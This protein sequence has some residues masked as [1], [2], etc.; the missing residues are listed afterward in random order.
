MTDLVI[1]LDNPKALDARTVLEQTILCWEN[2]NAKTYSLKGHEIV[3]RPKTVQEQIDKCGIGLGYYVPTKPEMAWKKFP[4]N[5]YV[6]PTNCTSVSDKSQAINAI[7]DCF[8][9]YN[10]VLGKSAFVLV[11][12]SSMAKIK[13]SWASQDGP[14]G[15]LGICNYSYYSTGELISSTI[16]FDS[17]DSW[18]TENVL[19]CGYS[20]T[21]YN[22]R[23][24]GKHEIGH[25]L[26]LSHVYN[27]ERSTMFHTMKKGEHRVLDKGTVNGI[28]YLY[29]IL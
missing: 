21:K 10:V 8:Q 26:G 5:F 24:C 2:L 9:E 25:A 14:N 29:K 18:M 6:D 23:E 15:R 16:K 13:I 28:K 1:D 19:Q 22:M 27:D 20:G 11:T 17:A 4:V 7:K 12:A 3:I